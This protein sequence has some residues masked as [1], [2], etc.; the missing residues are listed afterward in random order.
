MK[1]IAKSADGAPLPGSMRSVVMVWPAQRGCFPGSK[2]YSWNWP[3]AWIG[4]TITL[5]S[6]MLGDDS[7]AQ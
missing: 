2:R 5:S 3:S 1:S 4:K 6:A 7:V